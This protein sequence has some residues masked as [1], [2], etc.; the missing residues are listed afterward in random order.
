MIC[1]TGAAGCTSFCGINKP[2]TEWIRPEK[3]EIIRNVSNQ[4][5]EKLD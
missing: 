4:Y 5:D 3:E 1:S 2:T